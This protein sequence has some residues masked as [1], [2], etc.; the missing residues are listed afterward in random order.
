MVCRC[1]FSYLLFY[2]A[3]SGSDRHGSVEH[4]EFSPPAGPKTAYQSEDFATNCSFAKIALE[5]H[6]WRQLQP[7]WTS[8]IR[9]QFCR[10]FAEGSSEVWL[11]GDA[12]IAVFTASSRRSFVP[13]AE[14]I[15]SQ[16]RRRLITNLR[17]GASLQCHGGNKRRGDGNRLEGG[18]RNHPDASPRART[19]R[20]ES[21][22]G[23]RAKSRLSVAL[24]HRRFH[25]CQ[26]PLRWCRPTFP[27]LRPS[28][29]LHTTRRSARPWSNW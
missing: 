22:K 16:C 12:A 20:K 13:N 1:L 2:L 25:S 15:G 6:A 26:R 5:C 17:A 3:A 11:P 18:R 21:A 29:L 19:L 10:L 9:V 28:R 4:R 27:S 7:S 14:G 24:R 8:I 23:P